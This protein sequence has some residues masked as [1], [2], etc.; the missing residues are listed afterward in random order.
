MSLNSLVLYKNQPA[1]ITQTPGDKIEI[2]LPG[3]RKIKVRS[4]DVLP[5]HPGPISRLDEL[6]TPMGEVETAWELLAG[7]TT[8]LPELAEL[9]YDVFTPVTAWATWQLLEDGLYFQGSPDTI[10]VHTPEEVVAIKAGRAAKLH[11]QVAYDA[12]L[13]RAA[14]NTYTTDDERYLQEIEQVAFGRREKSRVMR[15]LGHTPS[16][17]NGHRLLLNLGY[18]DHTVN[19]YPVRFG[20]PMDP[21]QF[22]L[23]ELPDEPRRDLTHLPAFAIDDEGSSDPDDAISLDG[24]RLWVHIA[25]VAALVEPDSPVDAEA[26]A[27][28]ANLYLPEGTVTMLPLGATRMLGLGLQSTSPALSFGLDIAAGGEVTLAEVVPSW[29]KVQRLSYAAAEKQLTTAPLDALYRLA[30]NHLARRRANHSVELNLPEVKVWVQAGQ[31]IVKPILPLESRTLVREAMLMTGEAVGRFAQAENIPLLYSTQDPP[32]ETDFADTLSGMFAQRRMLKRSQLKTSPGL[33]SG[34]GLEIYTQATSP[35]R[36][37]ADLIVHQQLRAFINGVALLDD[38]AIVERAGA[39]EA[40]ASSVRQAERLSNKHW[41]LNYLASQSDWQGAAVLV[42]KMHRRGRVVLPAL[43]LDTLVHL[44]QDIP[45]DSDLVV[46]LRSVNLP[47]LD[48]S[49][50]LI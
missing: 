16:P 19:P 15:D 23:P 6:H 43:D 45:L 21:P 26:R 46:Q 9:V 17:E 13:A 32:D 7:E 8:S 18:W 34:L 36:R 2:Q 29:V 11:E 25:D 22:D 12:F 4:K 42:E 38:A 44:S 35:L 48:A 5:L 41:T 14:T 1:I 28:A 49:F 30:L 10:T 47:E 24:E 27:R 31:V 33:H 37:Y 20:L 39:A 3:G 50:R 40:V